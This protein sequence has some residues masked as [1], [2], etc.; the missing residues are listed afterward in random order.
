MVGHHPPLNG[1]SQPQ[2][3]KGPLPAWAE[4]PGQGKGQT[5]TA[6]QNRSRPRAGNPSYSQFFIPFVH[7][8]GVYHALFCSLLR[9]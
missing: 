7:S 1:V 8:T 5:A 2:I 9:S 6:V 4:E 3:G